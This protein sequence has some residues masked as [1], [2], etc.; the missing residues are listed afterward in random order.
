MG[1]VYIAGLPIVV[2]SLL[3]RRRKQL[4]GDPGDAVVE[5]NRVAYGFLYEVYGPTAWWWEVEELVR[6]LLLSAVVVLFESGSP[7]QVR[8]LGHS[9]PN[10]PPA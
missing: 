7:L 5:A 8:G 10:L 3:Y 4:Y 1:I 6:K 2:F 9:T